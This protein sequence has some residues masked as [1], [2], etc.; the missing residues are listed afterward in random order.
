MIFSA[1][2]IFLVALCSDMYQMFEILLCSF[3]IWI[4]QAASK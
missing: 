4:M 2:Q 3:L 1:L